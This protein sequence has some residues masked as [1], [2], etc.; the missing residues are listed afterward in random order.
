MQ[1]WS[2]RFLVVFSLFLV[3]EHVVPQHSTL[4]GCI[5]ASGKRIL[6][7]KG[8]IPEE[9]A[10]IFIVT[11]RSFDPECRKQEYF[12]NEA[13]DSVSYLIAACD[14]NNWQYYFVP[15][16]TEGMKIINDGSDILLFIEGHGKTMPMALERA[17]QVHIRYNL[18]LVV[19]DWPSDNRTFRASL[20][21]I[22]HCEANFNNLLMKSKEYRSQHMEKNQHLSILAHS[23][24]NYFLNY[25]AERGDELGL[26]EAF[27]D[28]I[29]MNAPA[30]PAREHGKAV[31]RM[32]FQ[33]R[34]FI[35]SNKNDLVLRGAGALTSARMLGN[36]VL[37]PPA[38][39]ATYINFSGVART[40]HSY[41][42]GSQPFE[43]EL[44]A[45]YY[46]YHSSLHGR[47]V[48]LSDTRMFTPRQKGPGFAVNGATG[49]EQER[50]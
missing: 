12:L 20:Q 50:K 11:N 10:R 48:D 30:I 5:D 25:A 49:T 3:T 44:P 17:Y 28:N 33:K 47:E 18:S 22:R 16:F 21:A 45:F 29:V 9:G 14:G 43:Y 32:A 15:G 36:V 39:N 8:E 1:S 24:G 27:I 26:H 37:G 42:Y 41:Y 46:F 4:P 35:T 38:S 2:A 31:S 40:E 19:F 34:I 13:S 23:I 7:G 6:I